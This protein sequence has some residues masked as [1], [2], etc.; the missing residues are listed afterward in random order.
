MLQAKECEAKFSEIFAAHKSHPYL[1]WAADLE[2]VREA[3]MCSLRGE[4]FQQFRN[5]A[6]A[7]AGVKRVGDKSR[8]RRVAHVIKSDLELEM[9]DVV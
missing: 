9:M 1:L 5:D 8:P 3:V 6:E 4:S 2:R 7:L